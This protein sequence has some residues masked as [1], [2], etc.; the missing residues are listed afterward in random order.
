M[1][2]EFADQPRLVV[3]VA[4]DVHQSRLDYPARPTIFMPMRQ[5]P[6]R[7]TAYAN[8]Y[9]LTSI[10]VKVSDPTNISEQVRAAVMASDTD[11]SVASFRPLQQV[12]T[13]SLSRDRFY[14]FLTATFGG[15]SLLTIAVGFY[16]LLSYHLNLRAREIAVRMSLGAR[17]AQVVMLVVWQGLQLVGLGTILGGAGAFF[18]MRI[19][20]NQVY[21]RFALSLHAFGLAVLLL[22]L[23]AMLA[24]ILTAWQVSSVE[25]MLILRNE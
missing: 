4:A 12:V 20:A 5:V 1:G 2:P 7:M 14:T 19:V 16:G 3:G 24:S 8:K 9:V 15:F 23:V 21:N 11:L 6:D 13:D 18:L 22:G 17:R 25:P 10:I